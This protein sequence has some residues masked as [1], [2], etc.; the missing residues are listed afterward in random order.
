MEC[1]VFASEEIEFLFPAQDIKQE[2]IKIT[3]RKIILIQLI[4][5]QDK[6]KSHPA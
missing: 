3:E 1:E 2:K 6:N 4:K 5:R